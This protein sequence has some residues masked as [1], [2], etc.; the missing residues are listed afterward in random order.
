MPYRQMGP[1]A[2]GF[3]AAALLAI[4]A[5]GISDCR[6]IQR[7]KDDE[8]RIDRAEAVIRA[9]KLKTEKQIQSRIEGCERA[10][11]D[12]I[13]NARAWTSNVT[14][15]E[16]VLAAASVKEDVKTAAT[17]N[18]KYQAESANQ[19]RRNLFECEPLVRDN[20][21]IIDDNALREALGKL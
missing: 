17:R 19:L 8:A 18:I 12:R 14:Y 21:E 15:L 1:R 20:K 5:F 2:Q 7:D 3:G 4:A 9:E 11:N 13:N 16:K 10:T 6:S